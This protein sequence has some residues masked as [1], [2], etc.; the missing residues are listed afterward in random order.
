MPPKSLPKK[1]LKSPLVDAVFEVRFKASAGASSILPGLLFRHI[2]YQSKRIEKLPAS[3]IPTQI[4]IM[5]SS[6]KFQPLL[7]LHWGSFF[8][9]IGDESLAVT[10][11]MPY[12]GWNKFREQILKVMEIVKSTDVIDSIERYSLKYSNVIDGNNISENIRRIDMDIRVGNHAIKSEIF[13]LRFEIP[14]NEIIH[15]VQIAAHARAR[16][17][18]GEIREGALVEVDT[19]CNHKTNDFL[20]FMKQ[21]P[22]RIEALHTE[23]KSMFFQCLTNDTVEYLEPIY[24]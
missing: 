17:H 20:L 3:E 2:E 19:I 15:L 14:R 6:L 22:T 16:L 23:S 1:L 24:E 5:D 9:P 12:P 8:V 4:R 18:G 13:N 10:C 11:K 7:R 21:L